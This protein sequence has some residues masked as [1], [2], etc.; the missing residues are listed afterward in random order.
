MTAK[1]FVRSNYP[2]A[3]FSYGQVRLSKIN[4]ALFWEDEFGMAED[5]QD[6]KAI[7]EAW[8]KMAHRILFDFNMAIDKG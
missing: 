3:Y 4:T 2:E 1:D 8:Y 7:D 6:Q 5:Y